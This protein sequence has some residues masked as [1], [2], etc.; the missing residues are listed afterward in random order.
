MTD[1][2]KQTDEQD[3][4]R[5]GDLD[6]EETADDVR[7]GMTKQELVQPLGS[8]SDIAKAEPTK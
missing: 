3:D 2:R 4:A 8:R 1:E 6:V 7:G 5:L